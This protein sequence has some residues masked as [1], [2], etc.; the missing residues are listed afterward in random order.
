MGEALAG[1]EPT[2]NEGARF[3]HEPRPASAIIGLGNPLRGDD[4][5]GVRVAEVLAARQLPRDVE[6]ID[7]GTQGLG[8]VNLM[9]GRQRVI[10]VD[11]AN[12]GEAPGQFV[13]FTLDDVDLLGGPGPL[14][15]D[16]YLNI[17][18]AG[19]REA[20]LLARALDSLPQEV[21]VFGVQP[22]NT[23]WESALSSEVEETLPDLID[24]VLTEVAVSY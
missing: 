5:V 17:H 8:I 11:A 12:V 19:L 6:V 13:R 1:G 16:Q 4:G 10:L 24:A 15:D 9:E 14:G 21:V 2:A 20:L 3:A 23:G 18:Y 22:A 7:G